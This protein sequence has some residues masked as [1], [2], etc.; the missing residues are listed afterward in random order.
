[1]GVLSL[2]GNTANFLATPL[3]VSSV[4]AF[5]MYPNQCVTS[6]RTMVHLVYAGHLLYWQRRL[7][8]K[9]Y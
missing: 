2:I 4:L 6:Q 3:I 1:M 8:L 9:V 7:W 5:A